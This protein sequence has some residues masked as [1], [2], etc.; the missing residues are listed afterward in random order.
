[1]LPVLGHELSRC[2]KPLEHLRQLGEILE[3]R[4]APIDAHTRRMGSAATNY[5][6][7]EP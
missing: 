6:A 5:A 3:T 4:D 7:E 2:M 1:M